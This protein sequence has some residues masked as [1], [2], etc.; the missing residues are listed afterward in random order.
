MEH[1]FALTRKKNK[2][3]SGFGGWHATKELHLM[4]PGRFAFR[5][6][7]KQVF[8]RKRKN[9]D[10]LAIVYHYTW[11][12][13]LNVIEDPTLKESE[14]AKAPKGPRKKS[15]QKHQGHHAGDW[16]FKVKHQMDALA[17]AKLK[18]IKGPMQTTQR[19]ATAP[20]RSDN[21]KLRKALSP[22]NKAEQ[23]QWPTMAVGAFC[24]M[25]QKPNKDGGHG[26][27]FLAKP[28]FHWWTPSKYYSKE[29]AS[30]LRPIVS[31]HHQLEFYE[32]ANSYLSTFHDPVAQS[33]G[34]KKKKKNRKTMPTKNAFNY[35]PTCKGGGGGGTARAW[36]Y[37]KQQSDCG[38]YLF[39][40]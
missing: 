22:S 30:L 28:A 6:F 15:S 2:N 12:S 39:L 36:N 5:H 38:V 13:F 35:I 24:F 9:G 11:E 1:L 14:E 19:M 37:L 7:E 8:T 27:G 20:I 33:N 26:G 25:D 34:K 21:E 40:E 31:K 32:T 4:V 10:P 29:M 16:P 17:H 23:K 18:G 3:G